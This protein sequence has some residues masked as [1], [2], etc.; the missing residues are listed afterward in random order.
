MLPQGM[1]SGKIF[2]GIDSFFSN[3]S[4]QACVLAS[5]IWEVEAIVN[6]AFISPVRKYAIK[7][8]MNNIFSAL[9]KISG[10]FVAKEYSWNKEL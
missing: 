10:R 6:S 8:G 2:F 7:S 4:S 3:S 9:S 1:I 5:N